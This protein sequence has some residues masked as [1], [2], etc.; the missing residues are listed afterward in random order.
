MASV[1]TY[2]NFSRNTFEAFEF[3]RSVFGTQYSGPVMRMKDAPPH[4]DWPLAQEDEAL[5]MH[6]ALPTI[7]GHLLMG[8]DCPGPMG[9]KLKPGNNVYINLQPDTRGEAEAL[10]A[11]LSAGGT[12]EMPLQEMFW[13]DYFASFTDRFGIQWM[14]NTASKT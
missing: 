12:V 13:G 7:G 6:C 4:P 14:I 10:Y 8:S 3:Y 11:G 9:A 1:S 5:V 2:L